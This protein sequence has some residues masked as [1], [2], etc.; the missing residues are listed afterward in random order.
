MQYKHLLAKTVF[1]VSCFQESA[2]HARKHSIHKRSSGTEAASTVMV[3]IAGAILTGMVIMIFFI[4]WKMRKNRDRTISPDLPDKQLLTPV[5]GNTMVSEP[6]DVP[7]LSPFPRPPT[8]LISTPVPATLRYTTRTLEE[9][10]DEIKSLTRPILAELKSYTSPPLP[11]H[12]T[13]TAVFLLLGED[14][15]FL[16][17]WNNI[18]ILMKV[19]GKDS[20]MA[21]LGRFTKA[22]EKVVK[23]AGKLVKSM[24]FEDVHSAGKS[25]SVLFHW[26]SKVCD[27]N[28]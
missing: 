16:R 6:E 24:S 12:Q 17:D 27:G 25:V 28:P 23:E 1:Q 26:A 8:E 19:S 3:V 13:M 22:E 15:K 2:D 7:S 18:I 21:R 20:F 10:C 14:R 5:R 9:I 11:V 4:I